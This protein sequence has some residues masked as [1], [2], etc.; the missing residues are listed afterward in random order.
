MVCENNYIKVFDYGRNN[1]MC[2]ELDKK[3]YNRN[4][5]PF[6]PALAAGGDTEK[7]LGKSY[8][9]EF[10]FTNSVVAVVAVNNEKSTIQTIN[11]L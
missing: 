8:G 5:K 1:V 3:C 9:Y 11:L 6:D 2:V 4:S 7:T 10:C